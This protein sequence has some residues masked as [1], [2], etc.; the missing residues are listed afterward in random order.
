MLKTLKQLNIVMLN[1]EC[2]KFTLWS[3]KLHLV[4]NQII[5]SK[6]CICVIYHFFKNIQQTK[7]KEHIPSKYR[8]EWNTFCYL[9]KW[10]CYYVFIASN[11][12]VFLL[13]TKSRKNNQETLLHHHITCKY[14]LSLSFSISSLIQMNKKFQ[15]E[16]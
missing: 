16:I 5:K 3:C 9:L 14:K 13:K 8:I 12:L 7:I 4:S 15:D 2:C 6:L 10:L 1:M 11:N